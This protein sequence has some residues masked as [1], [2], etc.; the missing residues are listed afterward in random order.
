M[1]LAPCCLVYD[2]K[3]HDSPLTLTQTPER[4]RRREQLR[5]EK[6]LSKAYLPRF[7]GGRWAFAVT[8]E[9]DNG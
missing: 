9:Q 7:H 5:M 2:P 8:R 4:G 1:V 6:N 3:G